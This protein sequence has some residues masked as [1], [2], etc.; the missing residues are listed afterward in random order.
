MTI[1]AVGIRSSRIKS[2]LASTVLSTE[3]RCRRFAQ[4]DTHCAVLYRCHRRRPLGPKRCTEE[5][6]MH[7]LSIPPHVV[8]MVQKRV[9]RAH[10][11]DTIV[12][13]N[14]ALLVVDMQNYFMH[15]DYQAVPMARE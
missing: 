9:G 8:D 1:C 6:H 5:P 14:A 10:P 11:Y 7:K 12:P 3:R 4:L 2:R 15:P 13:N